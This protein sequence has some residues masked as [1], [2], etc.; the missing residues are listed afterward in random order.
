MD[1]KALFGDAESLSLEDFEA[2]VAGKKIVDLSEGGY[3]AKEKFDA[4]VKK[5][6]DA[7]TAV[8]AELTDLKAATDGDDGLKKQVATLTEKL[9]AE[10][11]RAEEAVTKATRSERMEAVRGKASHL[12][13]KLLRTLY[14]DALALVSDD[15]DF[16]TAL[17][18]AIESDPDYAPSDEQPAPARLSSGKP[19]QG[20]PDAP[21]PLA[22]ALGKGLG[23][24][25]E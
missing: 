16:D 25:T 19:G 9:A 15:V 3:V 1:W 6:K 17:S 12:P 20:K 14:D 24:D 13:P 22:A 10:T 23:L 7:A 8:T 11:Q 21:D 18:K 2:K 4:E 5:H